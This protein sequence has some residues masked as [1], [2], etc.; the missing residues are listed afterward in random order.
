M[1]PVTESC[2]HVNLSAS[3]NVKNGPGQLLG[4]FVASTSAGTLK[5]WDSTTAAGTVIVNTFTPLAATF[6]PIPA[7][8]VNG[9]F[10]TITGTI[11]YTVFWAP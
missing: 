8:F 6:Y 10:V 5:L 9:L 2:Q 7:C 11:D 1:Q 3:A 4:I